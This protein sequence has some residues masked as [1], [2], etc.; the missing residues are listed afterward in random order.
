MVFIK[1]QLQKHLNMQALFVTYSY[2][3]HNAI[4]FAINLELHKFI[5][6]GQGIL[7]YSSLEGNK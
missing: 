2:K 5:A 3:Q 7:P 1:Q 6:I 4:H